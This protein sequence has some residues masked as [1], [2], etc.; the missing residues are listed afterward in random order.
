MYHYIYKT[1]NKINGKYYYG[2]H[3][4]KN[5]H[6]GYLGSGKYLQNAIKK[7]GKE[8]FFKEILEFT[9]SSEELWCLEE[10]YITED[11]LQD[12]NCYNQSYGGINYISSLKKN[13]QQKFL[14]HQSNAGKRGGVASL[15]RFSQEEK[16]EWHKKGRAA[17]T[18]AK[19][20]SWKLCDETKSKQK[21]AAL[22]R[23]KI[24][25]NICGLFFTKQNLPRHLNKHK[26]LVSK[27]D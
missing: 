17:S 16:L 3:S 7:Y 11:M 12:S 26:T 6:D 19:G 18:G 9:S 22:N 23:E 27:L 2:R 15:N 1:T 25:C 24:K 5:L 10:R 4:T 8:N 13:N 20:K 14:E 21:K